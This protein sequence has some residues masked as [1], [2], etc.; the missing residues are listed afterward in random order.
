MPRSVLRHIPWLAALAAL[1]GAC[2]EDLVDVRPRTATSPSPSGLE[3][4][5]LVTERQQGQVGSTRL[6]VTTTG[7]RVHSADLSFTTQLAWCL[8][9][10]EGP[11]MTPHGALHRL[12]DRD[13]DMDRLELTQIGSASVATGRYSRGAKV[14]DTYLFTP[15]AADFELSPPEAKVQLLTLE[16]VSQAVSQWGVSAYRL[17]G[18][19]TTPLQKNQGYRLKRGVLL[20]D[21]IGVAGPD[22]RYSSV[23]VDDRLK[24]GQG[25]YRYQITFTA[26]VRDLSNAPMTGLPVS[27]F[28]PTVVTNDAWSYK[29]GTASITTLTETAPGDYTMDVSIAASFSIVPQESKAMVLVASW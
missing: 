5:L 22:G 29:D 26:S 8:G 28:H 10:S 9:T 14:H 13:Q 2:S 19:A 21:S 23:S 3:Q 6:Y 17:T 18:T 7:A 20:G 12:L 15:T 1:L 25:T 27:A 16:P 24:F 4:Q 11:G